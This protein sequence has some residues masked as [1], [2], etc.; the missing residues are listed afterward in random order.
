MSKPG[1]QIL[2]DK[3]ILK[4]NIMIL[5]IF[6]MHISQIIKKNILREI[7]QT[8]AAVKL[9][10]LANL[11]KVDNLLNMES[12]VFEL[13]E[14]EKMEIIFD[15]IDKVVYMKEVK[16]LDKAISNCVQAAQGILLEDLSKNQT[17]VKLNFNMH[18]IEFKC[19]EPISVSVKG[20]SPFN[21]DLEDD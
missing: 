18:Q 8:S 1:I 20:N 19:Y 15:D 13:V 6:V 10:Y 3:N 7:L 14:N 12:W 9:S 4:I 11:L 16:P 17:T 2:K 21:E 5:H